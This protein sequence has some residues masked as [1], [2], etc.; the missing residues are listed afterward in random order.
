MNIACECDRCESKSVVNPEGSELFQC[1]YVFHLYSML[2]YMTYVYMDR[3][4]SLLYVN[5]K[6]NYQKQF[7]NHHRYF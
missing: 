4:L 1:S 5:T 3:L 6:L 2:S 7:T